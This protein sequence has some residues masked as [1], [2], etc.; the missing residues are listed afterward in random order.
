MQTS[1]PEEVVEQPA[2]TGKPE[3]QMPEEQDIDEDWDKD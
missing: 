3:G 1:E 2:A